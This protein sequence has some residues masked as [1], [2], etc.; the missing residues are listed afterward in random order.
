MWLTEAVYFWPCNWRFVS[1]CGGPYDSIQ[2]YLTWHS[3]KTLLQLTLLKGV[4]FPNEYWTNIIFRYSFFSFSLFLIVEYLWHIDCFSFFNFNLFKF[5]FDIFTFFIYLKLGRYQT[6][7]TRM[8]F[9]RYCSR[10]PNHCGL[11]VF[12]LVARVPPG[13]REYLGYEDIFF[14]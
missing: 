11:R 1:V 4:F 6:F 7:L 13:L 3:H 5:R 12:S 2:Q 8:C 10:R 14:S 9:P